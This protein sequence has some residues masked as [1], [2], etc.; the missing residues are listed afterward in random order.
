LEAAHYLMGSPRPVTATGNVW[1]FLGNTPSDT[2][3]QW[4]NWDYQTYDVEDFAVGTIR[5]EGGSLLT[6]EASFVAHIEKD[7]FNA[8]LY[9]ERAGANWD[10]AEIFRDDEGYMTDVRGSYLGDWDAFA[11]KM[12]HFVEVCRDGRPNECPPED[13]VMVQ[14]M[15]DAIYASAATGREVTIE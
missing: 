10:T 7:I 3:S 5:F 13:A 11:Y 4:P 14:Q 12:K 15:L 1:T 2:I 6:V 8:R 9:G